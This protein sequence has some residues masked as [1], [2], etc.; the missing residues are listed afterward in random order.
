VTD[1]R[2]YIILSIITLFA[3]LTSTIPTYA[4]P[5]WETYEDEDCGIAIDHEYKDDMISSD[6]FNEFTIYPMP[7]FD[8]PDFIFVHIE[9]KCTSPATP[10]TEEMMEM[11]KT[12]IMTPDTKVEDQYAVIYED[13][14]F[15][16]ITIDGEEA[17]TVKA[18]GQ[19][20]FGETGWIEHG[21]LTN[22]GDK[23]YQIKIG[24]VGSDGV[25]GF[26]KLYS[27]A[28]EHIIDSIKFTD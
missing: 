25:T 9:V 8:D 13:I 3:I 28:E 16:K 15:D 27:D 21:I 20:G 11:L 10:I 4:Q 1:N 26:G 14:A 5:T 22:H 18:G 7:H 23:L 24:Y 6:P 19:S 12:E 2:I 17:G